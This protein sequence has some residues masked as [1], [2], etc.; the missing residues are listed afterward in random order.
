MRWLLTVPAD[1]DLGALERDLVAA[2]GQLAEEGVTPVRSAS[3]GDTEIVVPAVG[4]HDLE[5]RLRESQAVL[6]FY[7]DSDQQLY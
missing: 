5:E 3:G 6:A 4:P 7:P 2:G 1:A